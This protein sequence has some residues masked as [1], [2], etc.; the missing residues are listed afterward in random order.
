MV[1]NSCTVAVKQTENSVII[2]FKDKQ[3][4]RIIVHPDQGVVAQFREQRWSDRDGDVFTLLQNQY[5]ARESIR[6][7]CRELKEK[8]KSWGDYTVDTIMA[9]IHREIGM[10]KT[11]WTSIKNW[12]NLTISDWTAS[13]ANFLLGYNAKGGIEWK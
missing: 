5:A 11:L 2:Q 7:F 10:E 4:C 13:F 12:L 3:A 6:E 8:R 9:S 1:L